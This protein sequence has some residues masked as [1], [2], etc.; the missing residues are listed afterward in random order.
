MCHGSPRMT[1]TEVARRLVELCRQGAYETAQ[2]ELYA[3]DAVSLEPEGAPTRNVKGRD[4]IIAK[5][6]HF[7]ESMEIHGGN[8]S[9]AVVAGPFFSLSMMLD[10]TPRGGGA[11][12]TMEEICLYEVRDGKIVREQ[13]FYPLE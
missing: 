6:R 12:F 4:A 9:D 3:P 2:L 11:R 8:V 5:G 1:P 13:F 7:V 10:L